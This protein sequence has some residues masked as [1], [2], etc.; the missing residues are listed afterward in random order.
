MRQA[1]WPEEKGGKERGK[2]YNHSTFVDLIITG[3]LGLR[4]R[5]D[6]LDVNPLVPMTSGWDYFCIDR[7]RMHDHW[8]TVLYDKTGLRYNKGK[9]LFIFVDGDLVAHTPTIQKIAIL[10]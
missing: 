1:D 2:D 4:P 7:V 8:V 9:G 3:L 6:G 5:K 10:L